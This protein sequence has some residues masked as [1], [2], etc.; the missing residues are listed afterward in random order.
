MRRPTGPRGRRSPR[1]STRYYFASVYY[2]ARADQHVGR[3][4]DTDGLG[5][6]AVHDDRRSIGLYP[7]KLCRRLTP[8]HLV[9]SEREAAFHVH[10]PDFTGEKVRILEIGQ[11]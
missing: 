8:Q 11:V 4:L 10:V 1:T 2:L 5:D 9:E 3:N 6:A 7:G